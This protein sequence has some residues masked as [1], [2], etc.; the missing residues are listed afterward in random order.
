MTWLDITGHVIRSAQATEESNDCIIANYSGRAT[1][2]EV[3]LSL[4]LA[5]SEAKQARRGLDKQIIR[6][7]QAAEAFREKAA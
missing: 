2:T 3:A 4:S 1:D 5:L 7:E 6:L